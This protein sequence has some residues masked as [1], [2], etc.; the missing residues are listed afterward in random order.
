MKDMIKQLNTLYNKLYDL[1]QLCQRHHI[2]NQ[3][4]ESVIW[5]MPNIDDA[6]SLLQAKVKLMKNID[7]TPSNSEDKIPFP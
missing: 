7:N 3:S 2:D 6:K 5:P 1:K 4:W